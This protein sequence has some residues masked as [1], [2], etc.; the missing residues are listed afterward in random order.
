MT[1]TYRGSS[2]DDQLESAIGG[3]S[4][5]SGE[6]S[7]LALTDLIEEPSEYDSDTN[8]DHSR[9]PSVQ[10]FVT[11]HDRENTTEIGGSSDEE[12]ETVHY[13]GIPRSNTV[14]L[15]ARAYKTPKFAQ[16]VLHLIR[17]LLKIPGWADDTLPLVS[18]DVKL[19]KVS[20]SMTNAVIFISYEWGSG[21]NDQGKFRNTSRSTSSTSVDD[22]SDETPKK[23]EPSTKRRT[24]PTLLLRIYGP[25]SGSLISRRR[26]LHI[27]N[28][29]STTYAIGPRVFGTFSNGRIE[30]YFASRALCKEELRDETISP[31]I[32]R[33]MRELHGVRL[34]WV[35]RVPRRHR[36]RR[37]LGTSN[38]AAKA[39]NNKSANGDEAHP[40]TERPGLKIL[41]DSVGN[42]SSGVSTGSYSSTASLDSG[43]ASDDSTSTTTSVN[44]SRER[45]KSIGLSDRRT[46][47]HASASSLDSGKLRKFKAGVWRNFDKWVVEAKKVLGLIDRVP[48]GTLVALVADWNEARDA[49]GLWGVEEK[50]IDEAVWLRALRD[51]ID[52][53]GYE[54]ALREYREWVADWEETNG[55]SDMVFA[56]NDVSRA[57]SLGFVRHQ[58]TNTGSIRQFIVIE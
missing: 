23:N 32:G 11:L 4:Y 26:E 42:R 3:D 27:L 36:P 2:D 20:G 14:T 50:R 15:D 51:S 9:Q 22:K 7:D 41:Q 40:A 19:F 44:T 18:E 10:N 24:P 6:M 56:H 48:T 49:A 12:L 28:I 54:Q 58:L 53:D 37:R 21:E 29:L 47:A 31:W 55:H 46:H 57:L 16:K 34:D 13:P 38:V 17:N 35:I 45:E 43:M 1:S 30:E 33:R 8:L 5:L 39:W 25:A 52:M